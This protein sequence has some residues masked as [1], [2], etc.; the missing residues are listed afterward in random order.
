VRRDKKR[1][2]W[3]GLLPE[4]QAVAACY[5]LTDFEFEWFLI[6]DVWASKGERFSQYRLNESPYRREVGQVARR[7]VQPPAYA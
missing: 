1:I 7:Q 2:A 4:W 3:S 6:H 5:D